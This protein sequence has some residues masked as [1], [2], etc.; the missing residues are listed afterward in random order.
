MSNNSFFY[1]KQYKDFE[2]AFNI[3][4][5]PIGDLIPF[6]KKD[7]KLIND[8]NTV[9]FN[10]SVLSFYV[11]NQLQ[12]D[13]GFILDEK[14]KY[15]YNKT[16]YFINDF[17]KNLFSYFVSV[18]YM[19]MLSS[20]L[21][22]NEDSIKYFC[23][24]DKIN[25]NNRETSFYYKAYLKEKDIYKNYSSWAEVNINITE[26]EYKKYKEFFAKKIAY[27]IKKEDPS[28]SESDAL[29]FATKS[30]YFK[31]RLSS[32]NYSSALKELQDLDFLKS[33]S[34]MKISVFIKCIKAVI[35]DEKNFYKSFGGNL[36]E[37]IT[38]HLYRWI[39]GEIN[40]TLFID[41][42]I[43]LEHNSG[44]LF[45]KNIVFT[46]PNENRIKCILKL[47]NENYERISLSFKNTILTLQNS[48][49]LIP[50]LNAPLE[51]MLEKK[52]FKLIAE[53]VD[54]NNTSRNKN[55]NLNDFNKGDFLLR[56]K[57][58]LENLLL[59]KKSLNSIL[60]KNS[61]QINKLDN[62][63]F[64]LRNF[65]NSIPSLYGNN[66]DYSSYL[67]NKMETSSEVNLISKECSI[68]ADIFDNW[69]LIKEKKSA[70]EMVYSDGRRRK[71]LIDELSGKA[72]SLLELADSGVSVPKFMI[73]PA[74]STRNLYL[75]KAH[76]LENLK[77][78]KNDILSFLNDDLV[79]VRSGAKVSM[80]GMMETILNVGIDDE[81]YNTL[82]EKHGKK[83]IDENKKI[84]IKQFI[85]VIFN[86]DIELTKQIDENISKFKE[87]LTKHSW[88]FDKQKMFPL[89]RW[90]QIA[91][92]IQ[93]VITS[94]NSPKANHW[95]Q[96]QNIAPNMGTDCIIQKMVYGNKNENSFSAVCFSSN[97]ENGKQEL[98]GEYIKN[99]QG[100]NIVSGIQTPNSISELRFENINIYKDIED[101]LKFLERKH[102]RIQDVELT[103]EDGSLFFLQRR[104]APQSLNSKFETYKKFKDINIFN[105]EDL[106]I[107]NKVVDN[108]KSDYLGSSVGNGALVGV[109]IKSQADFIKEKKKNKNQKLIFFARQPLPSHIDLLLK[110][111][112]FL[113]E[114]GG[115]TSH[116]AIL[117]RTLKKPC[118]VGIGNA[119]FETGKKVTIDGDSGKVWTCN[120]PKIKNQDDVLDDVLSEFRE[121]LNQI[122]NKTSLLSEESIFWLN[123]N[124]EK[125]NIDNKKLKAEEFKKLLDINKSNLTKNNNCDTISNK[126][127]NKL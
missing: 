33:F 47:P 5:K 89:N 126:E 124:Q 73:I 121:H 74:K 14:D 95:R 57:H 65:L 118:V 64:N 25:K 90:Q 92:S 31:D 85:K 17:S 37:N 59:I 12:K 61:I 60:E 11:L 50:I 119:D 127:K 44:T 21:F 24:I 46:N 68:F 32:M 93:A 55:G 120:H 82:I 42:A 112:G 105:K 20:H 54:W 98:T 97:C 43:S 117:A 111:D 9:D 79:S 58:N 123:L 13:I 88:S 106:E 36:W 26:I 41:Q 114:H 91:I 87:I 76:F 18:T 125:N 116:M 70:L 102:K 83:L 16:T 77:N 30:I 29:F 40:T 110:C 63:Q 103:V 101:V 4:D 38:D 49:N 107:G 7:K 1:L 6:L 94:W 80:P 122:Q 104:N 39:S 84:F 19:E 28:I 15:E 45:D 10:E 27:L 53:F 86:E 96:F 75:K 48:G 52:N 109:I 34:E 22:E 108:M 62:K 56:L 78:K 35:K 113:T 67:L 81:N 23:K 100:E 8:S 69:D 72:A 115:S 3:S 2:S 66:Q 71:K 51:E 99:T